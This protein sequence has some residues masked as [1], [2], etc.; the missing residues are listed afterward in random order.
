MFDKKLTRDFDSGV[1]AALRRIQ[2][3][4]SDHT[5]VH[6]SLPVVVLCEVGEI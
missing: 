2:H 1:A 5:F 6:F 3:G 4:I